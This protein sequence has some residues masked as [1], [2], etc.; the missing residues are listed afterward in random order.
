M[1]LRAL[2]RVAAVT[3][4]TV[5]M[6]TATPA[7]AATTGP[8]PA[9]S[10]QPATPDIVTFTA[11]ISRAG[12][13]AATAHKKDT[14]DQLEIF[15]CFFQYGIS[16]LTL[17][18]N[19]TYA[20]TYYLTISCEVPALMIGHISMNEVAPKAEVVDTTQES[21]TGEGLT[22]QS[23]AAP[24]DPSSDFISLFHFDLTLFPGFEW[25]EMSPGCVGIGTIEM[26]CL[27][28]LPVVTPPLS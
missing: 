4:V 28:A 1:H 6:A 2:L 10:S 24:M 20:A 26:T 7:L 9:P 17:Q 12:S 19:V 16:S 3:A 5:S 27:E 15:F 8:P 22:V 23:V 11:G 25:I 21:E 18:L 14:P 13:T